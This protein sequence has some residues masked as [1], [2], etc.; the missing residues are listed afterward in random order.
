MKKLF[1]FILA[2]GT[3]TTSFAQSRHDH[4]DAKEVILGQRTNNDGY[5][6]NNRRD[7]DRDVFSRREHDA[8]FEKINRSYNARIYDVQNNRWLRAAE[9]R[10]QIRTLEAQR[11]AELRRVSDRYNNR[12]NGYSN[13]RYAK[14]NR[15]Y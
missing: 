7:D 12:N 1:L 8:Q 2:A 15:R 6:S 14:N 3:L 10:R 11:D 5:G 13:D 9:K 4:D